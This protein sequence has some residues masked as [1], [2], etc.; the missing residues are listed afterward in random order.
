VTA[1]RTLSAVSKFVGLDKSKR[2][3]E[4]FCANPHASACLFCGPPGTGKTSMALVICSHCWRTPSEPLFLLIRPSV[5]RMF[6]SGMSQQ[7]IAAKLEVKNES[8]LAVVS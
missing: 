5:Q 7:C 8:V 4:K 2:I 6:L 3:I 1:P